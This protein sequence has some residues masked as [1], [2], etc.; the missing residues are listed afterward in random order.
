MRFQDHVVRATHRAMEDVERAVD[1]VPAEQHDWVPAGQGR[2]V[3]A[4]VRELALSGDWVRT[5]LETRA[6]PEGASHG[7]SMADASMASALAEARA[8]T[9]RLCRAIADFPDADLEKEVRLH[10]GT[11]VS[12][13]MA[14]VLEL[15]RWNLIYH[16]G[17]I[18]QIQLLYGDPIMH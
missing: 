5:I 13:P 2:S 11:G 16:L 1:A 9:E 17:Q 7:T 14:D 10:F 8:G 3:L 18:N 12:M 4:Q 6:W 15:H